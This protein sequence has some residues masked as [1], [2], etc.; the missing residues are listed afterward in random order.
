MNEITWLIVGTYGV[1]FLAG[2]IGGF[3]SMAVYAINL[4]KSHA[5]QD[6]AELNRL[7]HMLASGKPTH[8]PVEEGDEW[9][10]VCVHGIFVTHACVECAEQNKER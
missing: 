8:K 3:V 2:F 5:E 7:M 4:Y 9:K 6:I 10:A 1:V